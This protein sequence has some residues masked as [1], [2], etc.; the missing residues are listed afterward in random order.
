[1]RQ[2][3]KIGPLELTAL[4]LIHGDKSQRPQ[5]ENLV[6]A[7]IEEKGSSFVETALY[8][9][10]KSNGR[11]SLFDETMK[12]LF[13]HSRHDDKSAMLRGIM[14]CQ[15]GGA[16]HIMKSLKEYSFPIS[17]ILP[18]KTANEPAN[19][20]PNPSPSKPMVSRLISVSQ[21]IAAA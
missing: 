11:E 1:M 10:E 14:R 2:A 15:S 16:T 5:F 20:N 19:S 18:E 6:A 17:N 12:Y 13:N 4:N 21:V 8:L 9:V 3:T 7:R